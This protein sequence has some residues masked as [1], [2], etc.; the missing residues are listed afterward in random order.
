[1]K[2]QTLVKSNLSTST[3]EYCS[4]RTWLALVIA[5]SA[6]QITCETG[7]RILRALLRR[8]GW[9]GSAAV[10]VGEIRAYRMT[11]RYQHIQE[12]NIPRQSKPHIIP[13]VF[14]LR[15]TIP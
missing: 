11:M 5:S 7:S 4:G 6:A 9:Q 2:S 3:F 10:E 14:I 12:S 1:M 13:N 8:A 15:D